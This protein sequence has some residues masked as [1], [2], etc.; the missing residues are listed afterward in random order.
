MQISKSDY[1]LF[2]KHPAWLWVKKHRPDTLPQ[3]DENTQ[4]IIDEGKLFEKYA[5]QIFP[6]A[7]KLNRSDFSSVEE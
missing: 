2:L 5:E 4:A 6:N 7:I 1:M 3:P